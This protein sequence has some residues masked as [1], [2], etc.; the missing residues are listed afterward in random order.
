[1]EPTCGLVGG[2]ASAVEEANQP[3]LHQPHGRHRDGV[4]SPIGLEGGSVMEADSGSF[5][6]LTR[7]V[8]D[9]SGFVTV[10]NA[11]A[12][13]AAV[14]RDAGRH[15]AGGGGSGAPGSAASVR[16]LTAADNS[17]AAE[18]R[19]CGI[20]DELIRGRAA[21]GAADVMAKA[22]TVDD[23]GNVQLPSDTRDM[24]RPLKRRRMRGKQPPWRPDIPATALT[25]ANDEAVGTGEDMNE[26]RDEGQAAAG[27]GGQSRRVGQALADLNGGGCGPPSFRATAASHNGGPSSASCALPPV[28]HGL[29]AAAPNSSGDIA[30]SGGSSRLCALTSTVDRLSGLS[31]RDEQE[32]AARHGACRLGGLASGRP[33]DPRG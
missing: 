2:S 21:A 9:S 1:M 25:I 24:Q 4:L 17:G 6:P 31:N 23:E 14:P 11:R 26:L 5:S 29:G 33:P 7:S 28:L 18:R 32:L 19:H 27:D 30:A 15:R 3:R 20:E 16:W 8:I 22:D 10:N 12:L 13:D